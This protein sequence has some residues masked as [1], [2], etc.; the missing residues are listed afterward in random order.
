MILYL[1][2]FSP[3]KQLNTNTQQSP[4]ESPHCPTSPF[5]SNTQYHICHRGNKSTLAYLQCDMSSIGLG[6]RMSWRPW[7]LALKSIIISSLSRWLMG[8][9]ERSPSPHIF[10]QPLK[11]PTCITLSD[12]FGCWESSTYC[13]LLY[14]ISCTSLPGLLYFF[15]WSLVLLPALKHCHTE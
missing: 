6:Y 1:S 15:T 12:V 13:A 9:P 2:A 11:M 10:T 5:Y 14:L 4:G 3:L 8:R 7:G